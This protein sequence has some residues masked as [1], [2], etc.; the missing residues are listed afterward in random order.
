MTNKEFAAWL[1]L[2]HGHYYTRVGRGMCGELPMVIIPNT[3][4]TL[5]FV[6]M[7][8]LKRH[9]SDNLDSLLDGSA[10]DITEFRSIMN[11][12]TGENLEGM[13]MQFDMPAIHL[14]NY[15][16]LQILQKIFRHKGKL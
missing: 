10:R 9:V 3:K 15:I 11:I 2:V 6:S 12:D 8:A 5:P 7:Q 16:P 1:N 14:L 13:D 4:K